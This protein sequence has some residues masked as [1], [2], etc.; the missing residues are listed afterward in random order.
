MQLLLKNSPN[1]GYE[2]SDVVAIVPDDHVWG[3]GELGSAGELVSDAF[4]IVPDVAL[5]DNEKELL[6]MTDEQVV[7]PKSAL[8]VP[9]LRKALV[10]HGNMKHKGRRRYKYTTQMERK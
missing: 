5:T 9:A 1:A 3:S 8:K 4:I 6:L 7:I 10:N 2:T